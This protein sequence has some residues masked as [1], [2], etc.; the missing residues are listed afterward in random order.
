MA[1]QDD[2]GAWQCPHC[3][4]QVDVGDRACPAC[5][6]LRETG[7]CGRH[8]TRE[9]QGACVVCGSP[10][11]EECDSRGSGAFRCPLHKDVSVIEGWAQVYSTS[12]DIEAQLIAGNLQAEGL[13]AQV[14]SQKDHSL[15]VD[16]GELSPVRVLVPAWEYEEAS[17]VLAGHMDRQGEVAFAC[18]ACGEPYDPGEKN[19]VACG[20]PLPGSAPDR[21]A[22]PRRD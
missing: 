17:R 22:A 1:N 10:V 3:D 14:L 21:L 8:P 13:N 5:G 12:D 6:R 4:N 15:T 11:C 9:A 19:C 2:T 20:K 18:P 7:R 16:L